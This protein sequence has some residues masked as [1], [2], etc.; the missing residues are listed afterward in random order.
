MQFSDFGLL[1]MTRQRVGLSL[2][3]TLT[4]ECVECNG[5]G[6]VDSKDSTLTKIENWLKRFKTKHSDKRLIV[7]V[8]E[9]LNEY[10]KT[11]KK[12]AINTLI[13][14]N[15]IWIDLKVDSLLKNNEFRVFSRK[16]KKDVTN[17]V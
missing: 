4:D 8:N 1:Q 9:K 14:K 5:L 3:F 7:Y 15:W 13:F 10:I 17:E 16:R 12:K 6:R 2:L 11:S